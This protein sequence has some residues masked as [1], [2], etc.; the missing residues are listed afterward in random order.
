MCL[1]ARY[2]IRVNGI[3]DGRWT[4]WVEGLQVSSGGEET[5]ISGAVADQIL[6]GC[7]PRFAISGCS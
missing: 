4:A 6:H 3:L 2:K 1:N 7:W 5:V